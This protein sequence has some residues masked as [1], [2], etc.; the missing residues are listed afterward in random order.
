[1]VVQEVPVDPMLTAERFWALGR[2]LQTALWEPTLA[3]PVREMGL[4]VLAH[5]FLSAN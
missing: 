3:V 4:Q 5:L 1:M 2:F